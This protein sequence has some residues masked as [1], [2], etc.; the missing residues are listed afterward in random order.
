MTHFILIISN[1][2]TWTLLSD[3]IIIMGIYSSLDM[4]EIMGLLCE[5]LLFVWENLDIEMRLLY[6][7]TM[8]YFRVADSWVSE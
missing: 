3:I 7:F 6:R 5:C 4:S 1:A 8:L 2:Y